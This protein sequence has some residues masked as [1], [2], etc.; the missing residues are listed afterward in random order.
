MATCRATQLATTGG[1]AVA[2]TVVA[3]QITRNALTH[4]ERV[5]ETGHEDSA[6]DKAL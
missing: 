2:A 1:E 6:A 5:R 3:G 4:C